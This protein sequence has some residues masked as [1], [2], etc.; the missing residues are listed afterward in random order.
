MDMQA[1]STRDDLYLYDGSFRARGSLSNAQRA[2]FGLTAPIAIQRSGLAAR[3]HF[4]LPA[5]APSRERASACKKTD[6]RT[7]TQAFSRGTKKGRALGSGM[8][9]MPTTAVRRMTAMRKIVARPQATTPPFV[10]EAKTPSGE[11]RCIVWRGLA[12]VSSRQI[13]GRHA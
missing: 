8:A 4:H 2:A 9:D 11:V 12:F 1:L 3:A 13:G 10:M 6:I 7:L 5:S